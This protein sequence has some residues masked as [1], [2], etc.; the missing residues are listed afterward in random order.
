MNPFSL[1][2]LPHD[3]I[4]ELAGRHKVLRKKVGLTQQ[5]LSE[6]SGVSL[7]S[8]KRFER[9]GK[10]S[11]ESLLSLSHVLGRLGDF[12]SLFLPDNEHSNID[13]LFSAKMSQ[14]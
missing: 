11:L 7:G 2:K 3:T 1:A 9:T 14:K 13:G 6:R 12:D 8:I 10:I 4:L 5:Q